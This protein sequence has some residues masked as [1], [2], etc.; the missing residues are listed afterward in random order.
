MSTAVVVIA[1]RVFTVAFAVGRNVT[2]G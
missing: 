2:V 1:R